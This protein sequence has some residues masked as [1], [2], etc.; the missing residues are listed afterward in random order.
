ML[1]GTSVLSRLK[2]VCR[3][4]DATSVR[5][6]AVTLVIPAAALAQ[7][8]DIVPGPVALYGVPEYGG[9]FEYEICGDGLD[10]D[11]DGLIDCEES[12]CSDQEL[13]LSCFDGIDNNGDGL[14][15]CSDPSCMDTEACVGACDDEVDDDGDMLID[16]DD[17]D[18]AGS[19]ACP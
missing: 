12:E 16:C 6:A 7:A 18:C 9:P 4:I 5:K 15:D 3:Q 17:P 19:P 2:D 8:C 11:Y 13:C 14:A 10:N 1:D